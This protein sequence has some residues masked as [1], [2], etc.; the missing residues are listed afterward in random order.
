MEQ[1]YSPS[2]SVP[3]PPFKFGIPTTEDD[4]VMRRASDEEMQA[5]EMTWTR[6]RTPPP[7]G[8]QR[9]LH[10]Q[11]QRQGRSAFGMDS[12]LERIEPASLPPVLKRN[13]T[14]AGVEQTAEESTV[15]VASTAILGAPTPTVE[16]LLPAKPEA[17]DCLVPEC[18]KALQ[19]DFL[20]TVLSNKEL[21]EY[22]GEVFF[23]AYS[24]HGKHVS[25]DGMRCF[26]RDLCVQ[27]GRKEPPTEDMLVL[28][29]QSDVDRD[30]ALNPAE[31][32]VFFEA[33]LQQCKTL[34]THETSREPKRW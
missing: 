8:F 23:K 32:H 15:E 22:N 7:R 2:S 30:G 28:M 25:T 13:S 4:A 10:A 29:A 31:F 1:M 21:L 27:L 14:T 6:S 20:E 24:E 12:G 9:D 26:L 18:L 5:P 34:S 17:N 19:P 3:S 16:D 11:A 33:A